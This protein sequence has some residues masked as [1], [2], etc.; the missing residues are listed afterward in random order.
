MAVR[1]SRPLRRTTGTRQLGDVGSTTTLS[2]RGPTG[3]HRR[4][5]VARRGLG[6]AAAVEG[7]R[8]TTDQPHRCSP[9]VHREPGDAAGAGART[10]PRACAP[11]RRAR[12]ARF[13]ACWRPPSSITTRRAGAAGGIATAVDRAPPRRRAQQ[14]A[15]GQLRTGR[16]SI[17]CCR[18]A[19]PAATRAS[20]ARRSSPDR[21]TLHPTRVRRATRRR[22]SAGRRRA[23]L[24]DSRRMGL[25]PAY[26][27]P[28]PEAMRAERD[29]DG[30]PTADAGVSTEPV[31]GDVR[32]T[33]RDILGVDVGDRLVHRGPA[34][35]AEA[36]AMGAQAFTRDGADLRARRRRS[37]R[38][39]EGTGD[40]GPRADARRAADRARRR[41][42]TRRPR[43]GKRSRPTR[44][45]SSSS[46]AATAAR[47]SRLPTCCTPGP[48][49]KNDQDDTDVV[50]SAQ[51]MMREMV[52][53]G[54]AKSDGSG[55][56]IFTMPPSSMTAS[57]GTQRLAG[58]APTAHA[59]PA[60]RTGIRS[61]SFG[62]TLGQGLGQ[63]HAGHRRVD[64]RIQRRVHGRAAPRA[65][66]RGPP[67]PAR[68][69]DATPSPTAHG[70]PPPGR[71]D[72]P[73]RHASSGTIS[74]A[75]P[76]STPRRCS[77]STH[78]ST[79]RSP[80]G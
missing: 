59:A 56:I 17:T 79:T 55:G 49:A 46:S 22:R 12:A 63:R 5:V 1:P 28:L 36:D 11:D 18:S 60:S 50:S 23:G 68:A 21:S 52:D 54:L 29:R 75:R 9:G 24:A 76:R 47:S 57:A 25:G 20:V 3:R 80:N 78:G 53:S 42:T 33:M 43:P 26:H 34:V 6:D 62:N 64:V 7:G 71:A 10:A 66:R 69:D 14:R 8:R 72:E 70:A 58:D 41:C 65:D 61:A 35:S 39:A 37:A 40:G 31:P 32:A 19:H 67:V 45:V 27:G 44:N 13:A 77:A 48:P 16:R 15:D 4:D 30:R 2:R 74:S 38:P 73:Q 51:Q